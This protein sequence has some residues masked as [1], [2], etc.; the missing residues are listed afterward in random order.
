VWTG[1]NG[2]TSLVHIFNPNP[3]WGADKVTN[4]RKIWQNESE[5]EYM[6]LSGERVSLVN[7]V[8]RELSELGLS[9]MSVVQWSWSAVVRS[10][11]SVQIS[12]DSWS[13]T[14]TRSQEVRTN[15]QSLFEDKKSNMSLAAYIAED[16]LVSYHWED[17]PLDIANF[18]YFMYLS[19]V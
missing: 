5:I 14:I 7:S 4:Q 18:I 16:G 17:R 3:N 6:Q 10:C 1:Q 13:Q 11:S 2:D 15:C 8:S 12:W 19:P 9:A